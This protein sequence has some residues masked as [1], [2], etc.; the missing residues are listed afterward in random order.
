MGGGDASWRGWHG[1]VFRF[2][3]SCK[4]VWSLNLQPSTLAST[5][6]LLLDR[7]LLIAFDLPIESH[8]RRPNPTGCHPRHP[9]NSQRPSLARFGG[10]AGL[11]HLALRFR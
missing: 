3:R 2:H 1:S 11:D 4:G 8:S 5:L 10:A 6:K 9:S 7:S